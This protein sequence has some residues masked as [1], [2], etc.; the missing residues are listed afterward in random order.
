[1]RWPAGLVRGRL[2]TGAGVEA[3]TLG[4][5]GAVIGAPLGPG[6]MLTGTVGAGVGALE[7]SFYGTLLGGYLGGLSGGVLAFTVNTWDGLVDHCLFGI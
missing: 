3:T 5:V 1:M 4:T 6:A 2:A 7:G